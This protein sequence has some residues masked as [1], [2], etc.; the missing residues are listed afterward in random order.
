VATDPALAGLSRAQRRA[1]KHRKMPAPP[2]PKKMHKALLRGDNLP[3]VDDDPDKVVS[4]QIVMLNCLAAL[5]DGSFGERHAD[6]IHDFIGLA[7][8]AA[9]Q[10]NDTPL[11]TAAAD[12]AGAFTKVLER[13]NDTGRFG[14]HGDEL[15]V[16]TYWLE[17]MVEKI[18]CYPEAAVRGLV[19]LHRHT[20]A[21]LRAQLAAK[22]AKGGKK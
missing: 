2:A 17:A 12:C 16:L 4:Q 15:K 18:G 8:L 1:L 19:K 11:Y 10:F 22:L 21:V 3:R 9:E 13:K 14:A 5:K 7:L 6:Q 20:E